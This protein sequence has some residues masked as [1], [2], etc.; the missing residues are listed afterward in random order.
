MADN[1]HWQWHPRANPQAMRSEYTAESF[2]LSAD[3]TFKVLVLDEEDRVVEQHD[4]SWQDLV[5]FMEGLGRYNRDTW[6]TVING[7]VHDFGGRTGPF[8]FIQLPE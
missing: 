2:G 7:S 3:V 4:A 6:S 1:R 8:C 5:T